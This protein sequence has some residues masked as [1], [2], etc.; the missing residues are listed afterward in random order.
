VHVSDRLSLYLPPDGFPQPSGRPQQP[1][2]WRGEHVVTDPSVAQE[3]VEA[4]QGA[5]PT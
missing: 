2:Q 5:L 1:E 4:V 3:P